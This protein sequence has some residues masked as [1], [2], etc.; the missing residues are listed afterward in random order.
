MPVT[1]APTAASART[2]SRWLAGKQGSTKRTSMVY[3]S[4]LPVVAAGA[5]SIAVPSPI[6]LLGPQ[7]LRPIL[8]EAVDRAGVAGAIAV[9]TAG[10]QEREDEVDELRDH[11]GR[12]VVNLR[13]YGRAERVFTA[14]RE[15]A[16]AHRERQERLRAL[17]RLYRLRLAPALAAAR[18]LLARRGERALL[19]PH[20]ESAI[21]AVRTLDRYHLGRLRREHRRFAE[22]W[23]PL[24]RPALARERAEIADLLDGCAAFAVAGGHV[25]VL[26]NRLRLFDLAPLV[27]G[28]PVFA[29]SGGAMVLGERVVLFHDTPPE[30]AGDAEVLESGLGLYRGVLPLPHA[31]DA[32]ASRRPGAGGAAGAPLRRFRLPGARRRARASR[33]WPRWSATVGAVRRLDRDGAARAVAEPAPAGAVLDAHRARVRRGSAPSRSRGPRRSSGCSAAANRVAAGDRP[34]PR[35]PPLP[36]GGGLAGD[37]R[38]PRRRRRGAPASLDLRPPF[39][40]AAASGS[41][42]PI[43]GTA[44]RSCRRAR[45]SSTSWRSSAAAARAAARPAQPA[46]GPRP[47]R[48]QLGG[49]RRGIRAPRVVA[50]RTRRRVRGGSSERRSPAAPSGTT[51]R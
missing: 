21:A 19:V 30:G 38:L 25:A 9:V 50:S 39:G 20:R 22:R 3:A 10:W 14:D 31:R 6:V 45:A 47:V 15:L 5:E 48:R 51:G 1:R 2:N 4:R 7:R 26:L 42:A 44:S 40:V 49:A 36:A 12:R 11:L 34:L 27:A 28:K 18:A 24:E 35:Q 43:S 29:W 13:L 16:R 32:P 33:S 37:L 23:R 17:Q 8:V 41:P 46:G